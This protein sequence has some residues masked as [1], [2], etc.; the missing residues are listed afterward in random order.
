[1][2]LS[3]A[4]GR[5]LLY[6]ISAFAK[7]NCHWN[8]HLIRT[9]EESKEKK[10]HSLDGIITSEPLPTSFV[11]NHQDIPIVVI[12]PR[13]EWLGR[14]MRNI[15]FVRNDDQDIGRF[16]GKFLAGLGKFRS[17]GYVP[18]NIPYYC[19]TLRWEGFRKFMS[20]RGTT[21]EEYRFPDAADG[22]LQ[23]IAAIGKWLLSLPKPAAVMAV[24]DIRATHVLEAAVNAKI[25]IPESVAVIGVDNDE[26]LCDF[27]VPRLT[28]VFPDHVHEG[29]LAAAELKFILSR[30]GCRNRTRTIRSK[31]K[32]IVERGSTAHLSPA[33]HLADTASAYIRRN[34]VKG[35]TVRDV[36]GHLGVSR[37]LADLRFRECTGKTILE[38]ILETRLD[39]LKRL[40]A[41]SD[42]T[43]KKATR[44][45]GFKDEIHAKH[46]FKKKFGMTMSEWRNK[47]TNRHSMSKPKSRGKKP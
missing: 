44:S 24:H 27:T 35:I 11:T 46:L 36:V 23:D 25:K 22:S 40:L 30:N 19:S 14:R 13:S 38:A 16:A 3:Y 45:C 41:S 31:K 28:S 26:L 39:E 43:I 34:A 4:S 18:T 37:R 17:Y 2:D 1:M 32:T 47:H 20:E 15:T 10:L 9:G 8:I 29:E 21:V 33:A 5:D 6:G 7:K 12:G 42:D